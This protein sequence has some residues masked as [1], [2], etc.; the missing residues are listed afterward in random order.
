[1]RRKRWMGN[2]Y[3]PCDWK[4]L[5]FRYILSIM[6]AWDDEA[7]IRMPLTEDNA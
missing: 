5:Y 3:R 7:G 2:G 4:H 6:K 1:M